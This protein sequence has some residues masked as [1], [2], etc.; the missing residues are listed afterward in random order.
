M[1]EKWVGDRTKTATYWPLVLLPIAALLSHSA[2]CLT[3]GPE[4]PALA[5]SG[6]H[7]FEL[8]QLTPN[9]DLQLTRTSCCTGLYNCLTSTCFS[10]RR[11]CTQFN[12]STVNVIPWYLRPNLGRVGGQYVTVDANKTHSE[13]V[14]QKPRKNSVR[15]FEEILEATPEK[16]ADAGH[17]S[18]ISK[19]PQVKRTRLVGYYWRSKEEIIKDVLVRDDR[20]GPREIIN[21]VLL[22]ED[23]DGPREIINAV[24]LRDD[25]DGPREIIKDVLL[26]DDWDGPHERVR[27]LRAISVTWWLWC[28]IK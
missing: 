24:L 10:E 28:F 23:R 22:R 8:Q 26:R 6:S 11:I 16:R 19:I 14:R 1:C 9:S 27:L 12:P 17:L 18:S 3:G 7:C 5:G 15:G 2:G 13:K 25:R 4:G 20:D 21:A